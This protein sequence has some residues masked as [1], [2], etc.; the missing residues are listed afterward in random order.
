MERLESKW[1][2]SAGKK[3]CVY[4]THKTPARL[5]LRNMRDGLILVVLGIS[6]GALF[7]FVEVRMGRLK[8]A[9]RKR[10]KLARRY[11]AHWRARVKKKAAVQFSL[12]EMANTQEASCSSLEPIE[13]ARKTAKV[14]PMQR[15]LPTREVFVPNLKFGRK[16]CR[17]Y[18]SRCHNIVETVPRPVLGLFAILCSTSCILSFLWPC[19]LMPC[20]LTCFADYVHTCP[21]KN[22]GHRIGRYRRFRQPIFFV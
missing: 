5:G 13:Q 15:V 14:L 11:A 3:V 17:L 8:E 1:I 19:A 22:C 9:E 2:T 16:P 6:F 7:S 18:C 10:H 12:T 4:E 20:F 21:I